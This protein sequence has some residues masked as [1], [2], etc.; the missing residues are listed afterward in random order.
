M[1]VIQSVRRCIPSDPWNIGWKRKRRHSSSSTESDDESDPA[2]NRTLHTRK[3]KRLM[4]TSQY[5]YRALFQEGQNHDVTL[6]A[7]GKEW[8]LHKV[9]L[10]QSAYFASMFSGAWKESSE[11]VI[12][13]E[14]LD[15]NINLDALQVVLGS[16]YQDELFVEPAEV[17]PLLAT[18][19]LLQ[20]DGVIDQCVAI[21]EETVNAQT[22]VKYYEAS[23][24]YGVKKVKDACFK[25]LLMNLL[26]FLPETPKRLRE[27]SID[28]MGLLVASQDL[29]VI[30]T[31]FSLYVM[32]KFWVFLKLHPAW[33]GSAQE[34][35][36]SAHSFFQTRAESESEFLLT[37]DG[38]PFRAVFSGLRLTSL[39]GHPQDVDMVQGDRI[40]PTSKL[41]PVFRIQWYRMLRADQGIDKG[42]RQLSEIE[43]SRH[44]LRCG[45]VLSSDGQHVWRWTGFHFG[46][47]LVMTFDRGVL[48]LKRNHRT[49]NEMA[50]SQQSRRNLMYRVA[51]YSLDEQRQMKHSISTGIQSTTLGK[52]EEIRLLT[53]EMEDEFPLLLSAN[54]LGVTPLTPISTVSVAD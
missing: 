41:L 14:I 4:T 37:E 53:W 28:L 7:L 8:K 34:G 24:E 50:L 9:Y 32:L 49:E 20:L 18:A 29:F 26:S 45:R 47:D 22:A 2:L 10:C 6:V 35:I 39:I 23:T 21:M 44:S 48:K 27:I 51:M 13:I 25:W 12:H 11:D 1:G 16:L 36:T 31:E 38:S 17:V 40:V 54:F 5:I 33:D 19:T 43:F 52:N 15:P 42:P 46:L 3:R 30:Q